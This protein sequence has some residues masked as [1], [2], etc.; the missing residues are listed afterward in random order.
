MLIKT[1]DKITAVGIT[2]QNCEI[3]SNKMLSNLMIASPI[4]TLLLDLF[5]FPPNPKGNLRLFS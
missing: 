5:C 4:F 1:E 3:R 2:A